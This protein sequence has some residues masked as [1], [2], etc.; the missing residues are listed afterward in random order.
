MPLKR[1]FLPFWISVLTPFTLTP[2]SVST[3]TLI[4]GLVASRGTRNVTWPYCEPRVDFSVI[5]GVLIT[6]YVHSCASV[7]FA[8]AIVL[9]FQLFRQIVD[10]FLRQ[11]QRIAAQDIID[12]GA[13]A[14]QHVDPWQVRRCAREVGVNFLAAH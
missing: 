3:A 5:S 1:L 12:I 4:C 11:H 8:F 7:F 13:Y 6:S 2:N 10:G 9:T 14:R